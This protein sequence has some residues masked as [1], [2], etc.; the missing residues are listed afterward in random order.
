MYKQ[1]IFGK[2]KPTPQNQIF[3]TK[4]ILNDD[5]KCIYHSLDYFNI[6]NVDEL[7]LFKHQTTKIFT[8]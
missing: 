5:K 3:I 8:D 2:K 7:E 1:R 6:L 4:E